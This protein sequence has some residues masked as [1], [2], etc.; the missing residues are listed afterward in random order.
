M[1][2]KIKSFIPSTFLLCCADFRLLNSRHEHVNIEEWQDLNQHLY[3]SST[4]S[5]VKIKLVC[6]DHR[7]CNE[8]KSPI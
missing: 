6:T 3:C 8:L 2:V 7:L 4:S 1:P 5:T